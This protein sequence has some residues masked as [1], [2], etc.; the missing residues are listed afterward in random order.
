MNQPMAV[1]D[2]ASQSDGGLAARPESPSPRRAES[3]EGRS[4]AGQGSSRRDAG[5]DVLLYQP[6]GTRTS[7]N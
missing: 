3:R 6:G 2:G 1:W 7:Q 5:P 4:L